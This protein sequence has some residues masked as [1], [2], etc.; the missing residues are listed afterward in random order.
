M[1]KWILAI[2]AVL[3]LAGSAAAFDPTAFTRCEAGTA[4]AASVTNLTG[5]WKDACA[6]FEWD[7][8]SD[9]DFNNFVVTTT[10]NNDA[11]NGLDVNLTAGA[12][13]LCTLQDSQWVKAIVYRVDGNADGYCL[14]IEPDAN[15]TVN[16]GTMTQAGRYLAFNVMVAF[17]GL[18]GLIII[19]V[20]MIVVLKRMGISVKWFH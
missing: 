17:A 12:Y 13:T 14:N 16:P 2:C 10:S 7:A 3:F 4:A 20:V 5:E 18:I 1:R 15:V 6:V 19:V 11:F 8:V 9:D